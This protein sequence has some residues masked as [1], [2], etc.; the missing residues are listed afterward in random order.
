VNYRLLTVTYGTACA[1]FLANRVLLQLVDDEGKAFPDAVDIIRHSTYVDDVLFG[2]DDP[3]KARN[4]RAQLVA[5]LQRGGF[6]LRKWAANDPALLSDLPFAEH[7]LAIDLSKEDSVVLKVLGITWLPKEDAFS[8]HVTDISNARSTK[9]TVLSL[10]ARLFDP[11]G[12][13]SPVIIRAKIL[14]QDL[15]LVKTDW[16]DAVLPSIFEI[17]ETYC[18]K[19]PKLFALR[20]PRWIGIT[21]SHRVSEL[22]GFAD[23]SQRAYSAVVYL[24]VLNSP[25]DIFRWRCSQRNLKSHR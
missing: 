15:W 2:A 1:P 22:Y 13:A 12:W 18:R 7:Q 16:D 8:F 10:I 25:T 6:N 20:I 14:M 24:R 4:I 11:F 17:W 19:L 9:R 3:E 21:Q 23:A 5:L